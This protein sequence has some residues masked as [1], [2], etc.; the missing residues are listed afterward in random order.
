MKTILIADEDEKVKNVVRLM[1]ERIGYEIVAT[2]GGVDTILK[3]E[4]IKPDI[5]MANVSLSDKDGYEVSREIKNNPLLKDTP[6][7]LLTSSLGTFDETRAVEVCADDFIIKP[8]KFAEIIKKVEFFTNRLVEDLV[9][10]NL[11]VENFVLSW[12]LIEKPE[13]PAEIE[14]LKQEEAQV[15][16]VV[17]EEERKQQEQ[18]STLDPRLIDIEMIPVREELEIVADKSKTKYT[19]PWIYMT[20]GG[21][22]TLGLLIVGLAGR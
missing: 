12:N 22:I 8:F 14:G 7:I 20:V 1:F 4:K 3:A 10:N 18:I 15:E 2:S 19:F 21:L 9:S 16:I 13:S 11:S 5:V 17:Q 6:V